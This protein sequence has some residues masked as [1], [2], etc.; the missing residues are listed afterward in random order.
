[1]IK[2]NTTTDNDEYFDKKECDKCDVIVLKN[3]VL[4]THGTKANRNVKLYEGAELVVDNASSYTVNSLALRRENDTVSS[5]YLNGGTLTVND[6]IYFDLYITPDDWHYISLPGNFSLSNVKYAD[7][8]TPVHTKD[9]WA[10]HYDGKL[11]S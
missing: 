8:K 4:T 3:K 6:K 11:R 9:F 10:R 5:L 7:G 1:M 2:T